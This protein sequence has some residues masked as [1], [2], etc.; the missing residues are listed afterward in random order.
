M[1]RSWRL[2]VA[3]PALGLL[4]GCS[5][6]SVNYDYDRSAAFADMHTYRW[7]TPADGAAAGAGSTPANP[8]KPQAG[9]APNPIM[10][11]RVRRIVERELAAKGFRQDEGAADFLVAYYPVFHDR[12]VQSYTG[13]GPAWGYGWGWR[14]W[15]YG[16]A[17]GFVEVQR[18]REGSIVLEMVDPRSSQVVWHA[19]AEG[20]LNGLREPKDAEEQV[21][22]AVRRMLD[23]FPPPKD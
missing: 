19:V 4:A 17:G 11:R 6:I 15:D 1:T 10:E 21:G 9:G 5:G 18:F 16:V 13:F 23:R 7:F 22:L 12:I 3:V 14:P 8:V 2:A 20:A